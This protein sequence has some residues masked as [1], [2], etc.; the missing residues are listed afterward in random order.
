MSVV[1]DVV[2][3]INQLAQTV[4]NFFTTDLYTLLSNFTAWAVQ[5]AVVAMWKTKLALLQ[6]S[7]TVAQQIIVNLNLSVY[8]N[9]AWASLNSQVLA[10]LV[11]FRIPDAVSMI[12]SASVTKFVFRFLG[13]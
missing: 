4:S 10:M 3:S 13:F 11:F 8:L 12:L 6:F 5:W 1:L 7:W 9:N 2:N